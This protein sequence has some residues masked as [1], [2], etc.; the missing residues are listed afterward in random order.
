MSAQ[1]DRVDLQRSIGRIE[2]AQTAMEQRMGHLEQKMDEGF[3]E[4]K[5]AIEKVHADMAQLKIRDGERKGTWRAIAT[6]AAAVGAV[7]GWLVE[8]ISHRGHL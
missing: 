2:G 8:W 5:K 1:D 4:L 7:V 6:F 3:R